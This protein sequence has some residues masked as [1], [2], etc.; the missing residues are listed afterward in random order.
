MYTYDSVTVLYQL[1]SLDLSFLRSKLMHRAQAQTYISTQPISIVCSL[2]KT[3]YFWPDIHLGFLLMFVYNYQPKLD[4]FWPVCKRLKNVIIF[5]FRRMW[6]YHIV[7]YC[8]LLLQIHN[9]Q[10]ST[11]IMNC[12]IKSNCSLYDFLSK[13]KLI[14]TFSFMPRGQKKCFVFWRLRNECTYLLPTRAKNF[15]RKGLSHVW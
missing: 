9:E 3:R 11:T 10:D 1:V 6:S 13:S 2:T 7:N 12:A 5:H 8:D 15:F 4:L 14:H